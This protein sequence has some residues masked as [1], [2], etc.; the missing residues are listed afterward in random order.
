MRRCSALWLRCGLTTALCASALSAVVA[1]VVHAAD[2]V[3]YATVSM[4]DPITP[5][6]TNRQLCFTDGS[7]ILCESPSPYLTSGGLLGIGTTDP[8]TA[9]EVSGTV[10]ATAFVG[11]GSGLTNLSASGDRITSGTTSVVANTNGAISFTTAGT[12]RMVVTSAGNVGIGTNAPKSLMDIGA[13]SNGLLRLRSTASITWSN[14][15]DSIGSAVLGYEPSTFGAFLR[16]LDGAGNGTLVSIYGSSFAVRNNSGSEKLTVASSGNVGIGATSPQATLQVSGSFTVSTSAQTTTPSLY[17]GADGKVGIGMTASATSKVVIRGDETDSNERLTT[18]Q[19]GNGWYVG[20]LIEGGAAGVLKLGYAG[21][22]TT[23]VRVDGGDNSNNPGISIVE[24]G[25]TNISLRSN[26]DSYFRSKNLGIGTTA[27]SSTLHVSGT[28]RITSWTAIAA[29]VTPTTELDVYGTIS[30]TNILA[31]NIVTATYFEGDGSRLTGIASGTADNLGNHTATQALDMAGYAIN[32]AGTVS[33]TAFYSGDGNAYFYN[34]GSIPSLVFDTNDYFRFTR[35]ANTLDWLVGGNAKF[36]V[37]STGKLGVL[38]NGDP[39][40]AVDATGG[41]V[42]ATTFYGSNGS[43]SVPAY[44]F[45][46]D[47]NSGIYRAAAAVLGFSVGSA[48]VV[49]MSA[50]G[51]GTTGL[52]VAGHVTATG[53]VSASGFVIGAGTPNAVGGIR[54]SATSDTLQ[55]YT[56]SGWKSLTSSTTAGASALSGLSDVTISN[57]A[58]RDYLRYD[59]GTS[60]WVNISESTVMSTTSM[61]SGWPD[62]ILCNITNPNWGATPLY[63]THAP[64]SGGNFYY[65]VNMETGTPYSI[66][67]SSSGAFSAYQNLTTT[68]CNTSVSAL[69]A[70]G[71]AFNFIGGG[72]GAGAGTAASSTGAIQ[73]NSGGSFAGDTS[74]LF[75]DDANNRLGIRTTAPSETLDV[76]GGVVLGSTYNVIVPSYGNQIAFNRPSFN[77]IDAMDVAGSLVF[78][79]G[80]IANNDM[81]ISSAGNVGISKTSPLAKLDVDGNVS[82]TGVI[83]IGHTALACSTTISGSIRYET[84]SDT[85]QICTSTGWKSLS[86]ATTVAGSSTAASNTGAIQFNSGNSFAGDTSNLFWDDANNRLGLGTNV[87]GWG[88]EVSRTTSSADGIIVRNTSTNSTASAQVR[89]YASGALGSGSI[90]VTG[91][92]YTALPILTS[93]TFIDAGTYYDG[94]AINTETTTPIV[95]G[96][97]STERG[98]F[99][100][101]GNLGIGTQSPTAALQVS[102]SFIVSTSAQTTTPSLYVG[103]NGYVGIGLSNPGTPLSVSGSNGGIELA[104]SGNEPYV[105]FV[106]GVTDVGI[107]Q[108]RGISVGG[109]RF[110]NGSASIEWARIVSGTGNM[111]IGTNAPLAKLDVAGNVSVSGV[112]DVGHTALACST[113][114]SGSIRYE[115]TSDTLQICTSAGWKSLTSAT[116]AAATVD[117][118]GSANHVAYWSD[119]NTLTYDSSQLYWDATNNRLGIGTG[120]PAYVLDVRG[121]LLVSGSSAGY[122]VADRTTGVSV[123]ALYRSGGVTR[124]WDNV[125]GD[126]I[127]YNTAGQVGIGNGAPGTDLGITGS[128]SATGNLTVAGKVGI[129]TAGI[130]A[131]PLE[132]S[133]S[134]DNL[135]VSKVGGG[136]NPYLSWYNDGTRQ[137][138]MGYG[139]KNTDFDITTENGT[140]L[141]ITGNAG[142]ALAT[143][144]GEITANDRLAMF[145]NARMTGGTSNSIAFGTT[146]VAA[147][148]AGS[149]GMKLQLYGSTPNSMASSD[150]ALGIEGS[151]LWLNSSGGIKL[152]SGATLRAE[153]ASTGTISATAFHSSNGDS[154][155]AP[156]FTW[157]GDTNT[158]MYHPVADVIA[159]SINGTERARVF[160]T[161]VSTTGV[162]YAGNGSTATPAFNFASDMNTGMY[163]A[164]TDTIGFSI[165]GTDR[166]RITSNVSLTGALVMTSGTV[167]DAGGGWHRSYGNTGWYNGTYG[168]GWYMTDTTYIRNYGSK[169]VLLNANIT[170]PA[171]LYSSDRR[172]KKDIKPISGGLAKLDAIEPVT[173][174]FVSDTAPRREHLGVIAQDVEKV[175]PQAVYTDE[176]GFKRVDYPA[177]VPALIAAV[178]ELKA[179]NDNFKAAN[180]NLLHRVEALETERKASTR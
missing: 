107:S 153:M 169:Q 128:V 40:A 13:T 126:V 47:T 80:G 67:F 14:F 100:G 148:G 115:T 34:N 31:A 28:A 156:G 96:T 78:R 1:P 60:K 127:T 132:V 87:P 42:S 89:M 147:P 16:G 164:G 68:D 46:N 180:D 111:G 85:L 25:N 62:A 179:A 173:F 106:N 125:A 112:I 168:G 101:S 174:T 103:S 17:V 151:N 178:K 75:W 172:L 8:Q 69:Y 161:G 130:A 41:T 120:S 134:G 152:Y 117:G 113:T 137:A 64:D 11:D 129:A 123:S 63:L 98:R 6:L 140:R 39:Q 4:T 119:A 171:F 92:N 65:R 52:A 110:M 20:E 175:Y 118:A 93:R 7:D 84:T 12:E 144:T 141:D 167:I 97:N 44:S 26:E 35:S 43:V 95:F 81:M 159:W 86:S 124:L 82:V 3:D 73:F 74:N 142:I 131:V 18:W 150:Y 22:N 99:D 91:A 143:A 45:S 10:S 163:R 24:N 57:V 2:W 158:G 56:G 160:S 88:L 139:T 19:S 55:V 177:L 108:I 37:D 166:V 114:I 71:K 49:S 138:Y 48:N 176:Q 136:T 15:A 170:A 70:A 50:D 122:Y 23:Y 162:Y 145:A 154:A 165:N 135:R 121:G 21:V 9:L 54:Y 133:S 38:G 58:G 109:M 157:I 155:A 27:P 53:V 104:R 33:G 105:Y 102:G 36:T 61:V 30:A 116:V 77:Y 83:D 94:V 32:A 72:A 66:A 90:G 76:S 51:I 5:K 59:A 146:G 149:I 29:N 79:T